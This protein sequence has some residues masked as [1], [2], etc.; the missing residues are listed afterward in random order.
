MH[1]YT[2]G[3]VV[4]STMVPL[5]VP[6]TLLPQLLSLC[7]SLAI[8]HLKAFNLTMSSSG[9]G[10]TYTGSGTNSQAS[11]LDLYH[12]LSL[13]NGPLTDNKQGNHWCSRNYGTG[14]KRQR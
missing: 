4:Y 2:P 1:I 9:K 6:T 11:S 7:L 3:Y 13:H 12:Q 10:Y 5:F 14:S 8:T